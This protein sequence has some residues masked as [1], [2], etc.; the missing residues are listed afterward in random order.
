VDLFILEQLFFI[1]F[2]IQFGLEL[3]TA[4]QALYHLS[5]TLSP[6]ALGIF[7]TQPH[8]YDWPSMD[9]YLPIYA[10]LRAR[11]VGAHDHTQLLLHEIGSH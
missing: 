11:I 2:W 3:K 1:L 10:S 4:R 5:H 6:F 8:V 7:P 9:P